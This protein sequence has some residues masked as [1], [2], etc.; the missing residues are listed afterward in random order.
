M[1]AASLTAFLYFSALLK[2]R[3]ETALSVTLWFAV[4]DKTMMI[5]V[6]VTLHAFVERKLLP[7]HLM[8]VSEG[9]NVNTRGVR[10]N[11][12][13]KDKKKKQ[14]TQHPH[15]GMSP[16]LVT[17]HMHRSEVWEV[18]VT[19]KGESWGGGKGMQRRK[20]RRTPRREL[21]VSSNLWE[22]REFYKLSN[23]TPHWERTRR[24]TESHAWLCG[25]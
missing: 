6:G 7:Q 4:F 11:C 1:A 13:E 2:S 17:V 14:E 23:G 3:L 22:D 8:M 19:V 9:E 5:N 15:S 12:F 25:R 21:F 10:E 18:S 16:G 20:E 24:R